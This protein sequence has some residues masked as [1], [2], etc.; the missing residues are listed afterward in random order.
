MGGLQYQLVQFRIASV[1]LCVVW[2]KGQVNKHHDD[3]PLSNA[4]T[5]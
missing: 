2:G 5:Q 3:K 1:V 4:R